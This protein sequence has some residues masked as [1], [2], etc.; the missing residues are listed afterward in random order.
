MNPVLYYHVFLFKE[1]T[2]LMNAACRGHLEVVKFLA[3]NGARLN[4][5]NNKGKILITEL[6]NES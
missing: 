4:D 6:S 3:N 2:P 1:E 5:K